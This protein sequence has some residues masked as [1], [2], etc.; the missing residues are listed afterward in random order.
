MYTTLLWRAKMEGKARMTFSMPLLGEK[1][2]ESEQN[3]FAFGAESIFVEMRVGE[4]QV[5]I[6][7]GIKSILERERD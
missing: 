5:G 1:Q 6:P 4:S 2:A 3:I 7:W